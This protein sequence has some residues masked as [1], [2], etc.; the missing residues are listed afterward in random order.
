VID[1]IT[2][3]KAR[4]S[5][6]PRFDGVFFTAV[7]T[8]KIFCRSICPATPPK[9]KNVEYFSSATAAAH[10]GYRPCL[11]C[12]PDSA[13][14]SPAW[15]GVNTTLERAV[16]LINE[17]ALQQGKLSELVERLGVSERYL[18]KLFETH[19]GVSPKAY[20][21]YQQCLFAKQLLHQT[22][23]PITQIA[24]ASGF[25]S[26]RRFNDC[27]QSQMQLTPSDIRRAI[28][29]TSNKHTFHTLTLQLHYRP[30]YH[31][32][33]LQGFLSTRAI[34]QL[35]WCDNDSYGRTFEW[36]SSYGHFTAHHIAEKNKFTVEITVN[37]VN[38]LKPIVNNIRRLLDIDADTQKIEEDLAP[39]FK[40]ADNTL[41]KGLRLPGIWN[42]YEAGIRAIL[43]QQ[44]SVA[45]A[46]RLVG[47]LVEELGLPVGDGSPQENKKS[48]QSN[49]NTPQM[50]LFPSPV[51]L[52]KSEF[53]FFKMPLSRKQT[54]N[55]LSQHYLQ[56]DEP[57]IP[58][59]WAELK[60]IGPWTINYAKLRGLSDPDIFLAGDLGIK[61][62]IE[63]LGYPLASDKASPWGSYLTMHLWNSL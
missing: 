46:H 23:M 16:L 30:P 61:K 3:H 21:L 52:A 14:G 43:G 49:N 18:R 29:K 27:F 59:H 42:V 63:K 22:P 20:A 60:G 7:K 10:A 2:C 26:V 38:H 19:L 44:V 15:K 12:R 25:N 8:T 39:L 45:A 40:N 31:W 62:S 11:R 47:I 58:N 48:Q 1:P 33:H 17:G 9:E 41:E 51:R 53:T 4:L 35:E 28:K 37:E 57:D 50:R 54:L 24:L 34:P 55:N 56:H 5:R 6:D 13:P 36:L 32:Q